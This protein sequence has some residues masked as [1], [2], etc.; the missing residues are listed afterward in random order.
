MLV[1]RDS[2]VAFL[3]YSSQSS[4][5]SS[6]VV[7][8]CLCLRLCRLL[9]YRIDDDVLVVEHSSHFVGDVVAVVVVVV[10]CVCVDC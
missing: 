3:L 6:H 5:Y 1:V 7:G 8:Y 2:R 10:V 4:R 9:M